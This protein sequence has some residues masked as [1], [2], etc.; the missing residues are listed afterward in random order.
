MKRFAPLA[1]L[2]AVVL[3][4]GCSLPFGQKD[5]FAGRIVSETAPSQQREVSET[6]RGTM[7]AIPLSVQSKATHRLLEESGQEVLARSQT[8]DLSSFITKTADFTGTIETDGNDLIFTV[9]Q[10]IPVVLETETESGSVI[11]ETGSIATESGKTVPTPEES[12]PTCGGTRN[13]TCPNGYR[14]EL[15]AIGG[16]GMC[17]KLDFSATESSPMPASVPTVPEQVPSFDPTRM[18]PYENPYVH[19][20][21]AIPKS[22][23]FHSFGAQGSDLW[24]IEIGQSEINAQGEGK[25]LFR[26]APGARGSGEESNATLFTV[27]KPR[28]TETH[29]EVSGPVEYTSVIR[30][31]AASIENKL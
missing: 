26:I 6:L 20:S 16:E 2:C 10:A 17:I 5:P 15:S 27:T 8:V 13:R 23:Y 9:S 18:T 22:W 4:A 31:V 12:G 1:A 25:V 19:F 11:V 28:D 3:L 30:A 7:E 29:F 14:C 24:R 21:L